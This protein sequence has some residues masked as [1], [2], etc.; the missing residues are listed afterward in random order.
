MNTGRT[1]SVVLAAL[2]LLIATPLLVVAAQR[3]E[4]TLKSE[5]WYR[6]DGLGYNITITLTEDGT[7]DARWRGCRGEYGSSQGVWVDQGFEIVLAPERENGLMEGHLRTL[8]RLK[9]HGTEVLVP[10]EDVQRVLHDFNRFND[11]ERW[12]AFDA[13]RREKVTVF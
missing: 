4:S 1:F 6:G 2:T 12:I 11:D 8:R 3:V 7:Y 9:L 5:R 10:P 13:F